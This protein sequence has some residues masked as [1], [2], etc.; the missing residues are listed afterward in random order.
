MFC[1]YIFAEFTWISPKV[2]V[3]FL[4]YLQKDLVK[5]L[6][7]NKTFRHRM[8]ARRNDNMILINLIIKNTK[9]TH[10][11]SIKEIIILPTHLIYVENICFANWLINHIK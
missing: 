11:E 6:A 3:F 5:H 8:L 7:Q 2:W 1:Y 9:Q 4:L 10:I